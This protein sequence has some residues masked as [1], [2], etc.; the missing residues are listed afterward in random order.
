MFDTDL[1]D[2]GVTDADDR[3]RLLN[4]YSRC[5]NRNKLANQRL[6]ETLVLFLQPLVK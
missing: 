2:I 3:R 5:F 6:C 4:L 1:V